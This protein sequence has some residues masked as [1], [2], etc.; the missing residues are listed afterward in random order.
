MGAVLA[1][2][3]IDPIGGR[4][5]NAERILGILHLIGAVPMSQLSRVGMEHGKSHDG[6]EGERRPIQAHRE[7]DVA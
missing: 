5:F 2:F 7:V 4:Y 1:P 3:V 6:V